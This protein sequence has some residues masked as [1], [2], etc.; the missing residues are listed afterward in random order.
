MFKIEFTRA[1]I[2]TL[3]ESLASAEDSLLVMADERDEDEPGV[4]ADMRRDAKKVSVLLEKIEGAAVGVT[5]RYGS[6]LR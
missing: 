4:S 2:I 6:K 3:I 5:T 1:E